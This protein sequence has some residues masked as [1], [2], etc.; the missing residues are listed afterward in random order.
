M[1]SSCTVVDK[2][3]RGKQAERVGLIDSLWPETLVAWV[4]QGYPVRTV[5]KEVG[6]H[7]W[8]RTDGRWAE[9]ER[10]GEYEEPEPAWQHFDWDMVFVGGWFDWQPLRGYDELVEEQGDWEIRRNGSGASLKFWKHRSGTPEHI[11]FRMT[12]REIWERD[13]RPHLL[14]WDERRLGNLNEIRQNLAGAT[15]ARKWTH[16]AHQ[17]IWENMRQSLGDVTMYE[18]LVLDKDW[19]RDYCRVYT[20]M[21]KQYLGYLIEHLGKPEG[22]WLYEDLGYK[23]GLFA[24]PKVLRELIFPCYAE[25]V[26]FFHG[27]DLPV[28]LHSCGSAARALPLIVEAGFD[29]LHPMERKADG[30]NPFAFVEQYGDKLAFVGGLDVRIFETNDR[31]LIRREV[32]SYIDGMKARGARLIFASDHSIPPTVTYDTYR[33]I[34]DVYQE[35]MWY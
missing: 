14:E 7:Y 28:V 8:R 4:E 27:Y 29:A 13:Y 12:S 30:N 16:Y 33:Y 17:F 6:E 1:E 31:D 2:L 10:A 24:S 23:N 19:I 32:T 22:I 34:V 18:S 5:Y 9:V 15:A 35:R 25:L 26:A 20:D 11:G 21:Y 3:L